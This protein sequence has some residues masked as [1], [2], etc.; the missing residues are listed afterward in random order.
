MQADPSASPEALAALQ[1][2]QAALMA[3]GQQ[4]EPVVTPVLQQQQPVVTAVPQQQQPVA[5]AVPQQQAVS[6]EHVQIVPSAGH[7][8]VMTSVH[9]IPS[10]QITEAQNVY[11]DTSETGGKAVTVTSNMTPHLATSQTVTSQQVECVTSQPDNTQNTTLQKAEP[12][13]PQ[14]DIVE[15]V[16][17][18][19]TETGPTLQQANSEI[20]QS[21]VSKQAETEDVVIESVPSETLALQQVDPVISQSIT[22][23][24]MILQ[25][26]AFKPMTSEPTTTE[27]GMSQSTT[28]D[29]V[30]SQPAISETVTSQTPTSDIVTS[31]TTTSD[32]VTSQPTTSDIVTSQTTT[33]DIL[34]SQPTTSDI[35]TSQPTT[36][37]IVT[38]L[39]TTSDIVTSQAVTSEIAISQEAGT[40][41]SQPGIS[42]SV[43]V[44]QEETKAVISQEDETVTLPV[45]NQIVTSEAT[46]P[47]T[48]QLITNESE[49][50]KPGPC[51]DIQESVEPQEHTLSYSQVASSSEPEIGPMS[52]ASISD[53]VSG[54]EFTTPQTL[55]SES[56]D[57]V[58]SKDTS[59]SSMVTS[60][61]E[62]TC[63]SS[64]VVQSGAETVTVSAA[65]GAVMSV[66]TQPKSTYRSEPVRYDPQEQHQQLLQ[67]YHQLAQSQGFYQITNES[68]G[69]NQSQ[70]VPLSG[71]ELQIQ[72]DY[73]MQVTLAATLSQMPPDMTIGD[74]YQYIQPEV[75]EAMHLPSVPTGFQQIS[76]DQVQQST[77]QQYGQ[78][79]IDQKTYDEHVHQQDLLYEQE[80]EM[81]GQDAFN[82]ENEI[83]SLLD[84]PL[85]APA[86]EPDMAPGRNVE[87]EPDEWWDGGPQ[88]ETFEIEGPHRQIIPLQEDRFYEDD[89]YDFP[90]FF[91]HI[92]HRP[93]VTPPWLEQRMRRHPN[94]YLA[95]YGPGHAVP[96]WL[97]NREPKFLPPHM[98][99]P[100]WFR[101][102]PPFHDPDIPLPPFQINPWDDPRGHHFRRPPWE[103]RREM[104]RPP[105]EEQQRR[106]FPGPPIDRPGWPRFHGPPIDHP[107]HPFPRPPLPLP[108]RPVPRPHL[109][110]LDLPERHMPRPPLDH[111]RRPRFDLL[112]RP[113]PPRLPLNHP[114]RTPFDIMDRPSPPRPLLNHPER[115]FPGPHPEHPDQPLP[116]AIYRHPDGNYYRRPPFNHPDEPAFARR[117]SLDEP[118]D[119]FHE[120]VELM[121]ENYVEEEYEDEFYEGEEYYEDEEYYEEEIREGDVE[122]GEIPDQAERNVNQYEKIE[123]RFMSGPNGP[124]AIEITSHKAPGSKRKKGRGKGRRKNTPNARGKGNEPVTVGLPIGDKVIPVDISKFSRQIEEAQRLKREEEAEQAAIE[125]AKHAQSKRDP[126]RK[127][128]RKMQ[129]LKD[130]RQAKKLEEMEE[131]GESQPKETSQPHIPTQ[132]EIAQEIEMEARVQRRYQNREMDMKARVQRQYQ[133]QFVA[134]ADG[135]PTPH[136]PQS[137]QPKE[138][139]PKD[140]L[141]ASAMQFVR[142]KYHEEG[143]SMR[144]NEAP[145]GSKDTFKR[146]ILDEWDLQALE[147]QGKLSARERRY[148]RE[149]LGVG[150]W[151]KT[152]T[153]RRDHRPQ[154]RDR[155]FEALERERDERRRERREM[156]RLV[157]TSQRSRRDEQWG[158]SWRAEEALYNKKG[159]WSD[160][161][162]GMHGDEQYWECKGWSGWKISQQ[163]RPDYLTKE[164]QAEKTEER[165]SETIEQKRKRMRELRTYQRKEHEQWMKNVLGIDIQAEREEEKKAREEVKKERERRQR[166]ED[167]RYNREDGDEDRRYRSRSSME[168]EIRYTGEGQ[169]VD[170]EFDARFYREVYIMGGRSREPE[171]EPEPEPKFFRKRK[172]YFGPTVEPKVVLPFEEE[173]AK[174]AEET[175]K[176][177]L[178]STIGND[179]EE[180]RRKRPRTDDYG[181]DNEVDPVRDRKKDSY[182]RDFEKRDSYEND[183]NRRAS[184]GKE[185]GA[186][187]E[188]DPLRDTKKDS[189]ERDFEKRDSYENDRNRSASYDKEYDYDR[190]GRGR[191]LYDAYDYQD[192]GPQTDYDAGRSRKGRTAYDNDYALSNVGRDPYDIYYEPESRTRSSDGHGYGHDRT[193]SYANDYRHAEHDSFDQF[194]ARNY[195]FTVNQSPK[196]SKS[197][198]PKKPKKDKKDKSDKAKHS[199]SE[200][201]KKDKKD[202]S[203]KP[204]HPESQ[205][206]KKDKRNKSDKPKH[207]E[208]EKP[209]KVK[210]DNSDRKG[211]SDKMVKKVKE[212]R[213]KMFKK[214]KIDIVRADNRA[215]PEHKVRSDNYKKMK[216]DKSDKADKKDKREKKEKS[217][218]KDKKKEKPQ[219]SK[220]EKLEKHHKPKKHKH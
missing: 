167:R 204:K 51:I 173:L 218:S 42:Q 73:Q 96:P 43:I 209:K 55:G 67:Q 174:Y 8:T 29:I 32:I 153:E 99:P 210:R 22:S 28:S 61:P 158:A 117:I 30:T 200:K 38:S 119:D 59:I 47:V 145:A 2:Q 106:P 197:S 125:A 52:Q 175:G 110:Y 136:P 142:P 164:E 191:A 12:M 159:D 34:T 68:Q 18:H 45:T 90:D 9:A 116:R 103:E 198:E 131:V 6:T 104:H 81:Y 49:T 203:D 66:D 21:T 77:Q 122:E 194:D 134:P 5:T 195:R 171:P 84:L 7:T 79:H 113:L 37:D 101:P 89:D 189:Y 168:E 199:E 39:T 88:E 156:R 126:N 118:Y 152:Y 57:H 36:S 166:E 10:S 27:I 140:N 185:Y 97:R 178:A 63:F 181:V 211:H 26:D 74:L 62:L 11:K 179:Y 190:E 40:A 149:Q 46:E 193:V 146:Q 123:G 91:D 35:V 85:V 15:N 143:Y 220:K 192:R 188:L 212:D 182:K 14:K 48:S 94:D 82:Q 155:D 139:P 78:Q 41:T 70:S 33:G 202:K 53:S 138:E 115:P 141:P 98:R 180:P 83:P 184:C 130:E 135:Q 169:D 157:E 121:G 170:R 72:A 128:L 201:P 108:A 205:K 76:A 196:K 215:K 54:S 150:E 93:I 120:R 163:R 177:T 144:F 186:D 80:Y 172:R 56:T 3:A 187:N 17:S 1:Q 102:R 64:T 219:N 20:I 25:A 31:Q 154:G 137:D 112:E 160:E 114:H 208:T 213:V 133:N 4:Q 87:F 183:R 216:P 107:D 147:E 207:S 24:S 217:K 127:E 214:V 16:M 13:T 111:P 109:D 161:E 19:Q 69:Y 206:P 92:P 95:P 65:P 86:V 100:P 75:L 165:G 151:G 124:T 71:E 148:Y 162:S 23:Q 132:K 44:E 105:W 129:R 176:K 50:S 58:A 60:E